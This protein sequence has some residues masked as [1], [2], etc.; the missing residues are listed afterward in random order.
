MW[1]ILLKENIVIF[2][3]V[4]H[5]DPNSRR[6]V[7]PVVSETD[8]VA[9][10]LMP[11]EWTPWHMLGNVTTDVTL[12]LFRLNKLQCFVVKRLM[13][14]LAHIWVGFPSFILLIYLFGV[15]R[16][17]SCYTFWFF[18]SGVNG[19]YDWKLKDMTMVHWSHIRGLWV[20]CAPYACVDITLY[21]DC[22]VWILTPNLAPVDVLMCLKHV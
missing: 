10:T 9:Q 12:I 15:F 14:T 5:H 21:P 20:C 19:R 2:L 18:L 16:L 1:A 17:L 11:C 6:Q 4:D 8:D 22:T 3:V 13:K 7:I